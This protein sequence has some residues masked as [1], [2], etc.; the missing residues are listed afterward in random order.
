MN[1]VQS[2]SYPE[3]LVSENG[4]V[5]L[6]ETGER[7]SVSSNHSSCRR[8]AVVSFRSNGK[9]KIISIA[10]IV[11][12][13]HVKKS[14]I[15]TSD[16]IEFIDG[17]EFNYKASNLRSVVGRNSRRKPIKREADET[18][19]RPGYSTWMNGNDEVFV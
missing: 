5:Y 19:P 16:F 3:L 6:K 12:E 11:F 10:N 13:A 8:G 2:I 18:S 17:D 9:Y 1:L 4:D 15:S 7:V 14:R